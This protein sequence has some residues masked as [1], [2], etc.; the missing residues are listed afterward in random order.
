MKRK[1]WIAAAVSVLAATA[2][3]GHL[4][5]AHLSWNPN[6]EP[7]INSYILQRSVGD[8]LHWETLAT[9]AHPET[10]FVDTLDPEWGGLRVYWRLAA[11]DT[12]N[13]V[14]EFCQPVSAVVPDV[15][16]PSTISGLTVRIIVEIKG[17]TP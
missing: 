3:F 12:A 10:S 15:I 6:T 7:D 13:N 4:I 5:K 1:A 16:A 9:I 2:A 17:G 11:A 8:T 14:S